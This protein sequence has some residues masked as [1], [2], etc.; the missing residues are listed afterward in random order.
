MTKAE[1]QELVSKYGS[2]D[3]AAK[4][5][6]LSV[7]K[8]RIACRDAGVQAPP[9]AR[10]A[11]KVG[12]EVS[13]EEMLEQEVR[14]LRSYVGRDR[15][16]EVL[17]R[18]L[19][20]QVINQLDA[21]RPI[22]KPAPRPAKGSGTAHRFVLEWSDLHACEV[23]DPGAIGGLNKYDWDIMLRRHDRLSEAIFS[24][25]D[26][27][28]YSVDG[29][30][31]F[32]LGDMVTGDIHDELR[33]TN[34]LVLTEGTI[35][36]AL[37]MAEWIE[38]FVPEFPWIQIDGVFGNHGRRSKKP[39][40]K[41]AYDNWDWLFYK[42][43]ETRLARYESVTVNVSKAATHPVRVYDETVLLWH[44]DGVPSNM[45]GVPWGGITRRSKELLQTHAA[46]GQ[47]IKHF[48]VGHYHEP[49]VVSNRTILM[50]GS[51][52]GPDEYSMARFGGGAPAA[53]LL[54][55]FHPRRGLTDTSYIDLSGVQ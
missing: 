51:V 7:K 29:L 44:G 1:L 25:R 34:E 18:R 3:E 30:H 35:Q 9:R 12:A 33:V 10:S 45:P 11:P 53:Q 20:D 40:F 55:T 23:V 46:L 16:R 50:N 31:I 48:A 17:D 13:R 15:S 5:S 21:K 26:H 2:V 47:R 14:E 8:F 54:H 22:H 52:K 28:G 49:N 27:R 39:Q 24:F 41:Q 6:P 38:Q 19:V 36:L 37:D 42:I 32:G 43:L 4:A